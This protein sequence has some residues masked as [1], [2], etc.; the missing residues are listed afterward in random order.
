[1][2]LVV[3]VASALEGQHLMV[4]GIEILHT[5]VVVKASRR[6]CYL[7]G[8]SIGI[9]VGI[10]RERTLGRIFDSGAS[11]IGCCPTAEGITSS[12]GNLGSVELE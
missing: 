6:G 1:M 11:T 7:N 3:P 8:S 4:C 5:Q 12:N 9:E 10:A 2:L